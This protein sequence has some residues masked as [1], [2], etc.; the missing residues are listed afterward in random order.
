MAAGKL[1]AGMVQVMIKVS[2]R[3]EDNLA[4]RRESIHEFFSESLVLLTLFG[5]NAYDQI[6][7]LKIKTVMNTEAKLARKINQI[8]SKQSH[9]IK[10]LKSSQHS[11]N[12]PNSL[13]T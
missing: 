5:D 6:D 1:N 2:R 10:V 3:V 12:Q 7:I 13:K 4:E 11:V 9:K 8:E